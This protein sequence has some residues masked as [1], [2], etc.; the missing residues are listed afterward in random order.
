MGVALADQR[1]RVVVG[2]D[3]QPRALVAEPIGDAHPQRVAAELGHGGQIAGEE[4]DVPELA[5]DE[6]PAGWWSSGRLA[7]RGSSEA[8]NGTSSTPWPSGSRKCRAPSRRS[9]RTPRP[10]RWAAASSRLTP[11]ASSQ[12]AVVVAGLRARSP[13]PANRARSRRPGTP[14]RRGP[15]A[16]SART[17][18]TTGRRPHQ[19]VH[20]QA[21]VMDAAQQDH[22][23]T[24]GQDDST[25]DTISALTRA[26][27]EENERRSGVKAV[28]FKNPQGEVRIGALGDDTVRDAG[29]AGPRGFVPTDEAWAQMRK[30]PTGPSTT[31][32]T[33][34]SC[35]RSSRTRS[36]PSA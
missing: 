28:R 29:P 14:G 25:L 10:S 20:R 32:T 24:A 23:V 26:V 16:G 17:G 19:V 4:V 31:S 30:A 5:R 27:K 22:S 36:W 2:V 33:P 7:G 1:H 13:A 21:D 15:H 18:P 3:V 12:P 9:E 11:R 8:A 6:S 35:T 34:P